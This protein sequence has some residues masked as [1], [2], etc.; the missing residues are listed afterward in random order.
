[1][2]EEHFGRFVEMLGVQAA[3]RLSG[4][5]DVEAVRFGDVDVLIRI[6]GNAGA[7]DGEVFLGV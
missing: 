3:R 1:V 2:N 6:F 5:A 4:P 7:D